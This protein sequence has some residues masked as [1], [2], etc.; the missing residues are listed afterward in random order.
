MVI[1]LIALFVALGGT[2]YA[3]TQ[4]DGK[5][6]KK[7]SIPGNRIKKDTV[8]GTQVKESTL[9][10]VPSATSAGKATT[11]DKAILA[12]SAGKA[13]TATTA[14]TADNALALGGLPPAAFEPKSRWALVD[15]TGATGTA[16]IVAQSGG[17]SL[18][19]DIGVFTY[20]N[21]G[22]SQ[23]NTH[24]SVSYGKLS[25]ASTEEFVQTGVCGVAAGGPAGV[26][27][28]PG[29][30]NNPNHIVVWHNE[31]AFYYIVVSPN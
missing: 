22:S 26:I 9:G 8:T 21:F 23:A 31:D 7:G 2:V 30:T 5:S 11:A 29:G 1:S 25:G 14:T 12:D 24:I 6:I 10:T 4:I 28:I 20:L 3:A 17:I 16:S 19:T 15:A 13:G 27:C 18:T